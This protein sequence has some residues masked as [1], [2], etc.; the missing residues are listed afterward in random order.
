MHKKE[1]ISVLLNDEY[2][3]IIKCNVLHEAVGKK[4][5]LA[6]PFKFGNV[7]IKPYRLAK[8]KL[9]T[10]FL[11]CMENLVCAS[12]RAVVAYHGILKHVVILKGSCP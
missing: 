4:S 12:L 6:V 2:F 11:D 8:V 1:D 7:G 9:V 10:D 5:R 3:Q